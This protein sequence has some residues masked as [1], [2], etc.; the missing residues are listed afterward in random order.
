MAS[1]HCHSEI[2]VKNPEENN[3]STGFFHGRREQIRMTIFFMLKL[4]FYFRL[5]RAAKFFRT[6][7]SA[8]LITV[9]LFLAVFSA[10][11]VGLY[12]FFLRGF[13]FL[14]MDTYLAEPISL[15]FYELFLLVLGAVIMFSSL[16]TGLFGLFRR[17]DDNWLLSSPGYR[18]LPKLVLI[19]SVISGLWPL[20]IV[21]LPTV[22]A[23][24]KVYSLSLPGI[25]FILLSF[26][27]YL[28]VIS[29]LTLL[30]IIIV[31]KFLFLI[32]KRTNRQFFTFGRLVTA[33]I[34]LISVA[35]IFIWQQSINTDIIELFKANRPENQAIDLNSI[36]QNFL[37]LPSHPIAMSAFAW[38][39]HQ[40]GWALV[41]F[42]ELLVLAGLAVTAYW[43]GSNY[44]LSLW[45]KLQEGK[46]GI[47]TE[48]RKR[49]V[50]KRGYLFPGGAIKSLFTKEMLVS[51]RNS[52]SI[53][54]FSFLLFIW[55]TQAALNFVLAANI[56]KYDL[57]ADS[58]SSVLQVLQ[59]CTA[60]FFITAFVL[61]FVFPS[62]ST[63]RRTAWILGSA[64]LSLKKIFWAKYLFY[65]F[66]FVIVG[67][68]FGYLNLGGLPLA[69]AQA[70][71]IVFI[72]LVVIAFITAFGLSL[73]ALFPNLETDD[74]GVISTTLPGIAFIILAL[75]YGA[76][77]GWLIYLALNKNIF[78]PLTVFIIASLALTVI[79]VTVTPKF[80][81]NK[82]F[83]REIIS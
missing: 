6:K 46:G 25:F 71:L 38:Q 62:F 2:K 3:L 58:S 64:P 23:I 37:Y 39:T 60:V 56:R 8:K 27:L 30:T 78:W 16:V 77:G 59:F 73:G 54:W 75:V 42:V 79:L 11:A 51:A 1:W 14:K 48:Y 49:R 82:E 31:G 55:L 21:F 68:I 20:L 13:L 65:L 70:S 15:Y 72:F 81:K 57:H 10:V 66:F 83:I 28:I 35:S 24:N 26:V 19:N 76:G 29:T 41:Y 43:L 53:L 67:L 44:F 32:D 9:F 61:R 47:T 52:K 40:S 12:Y 17:N 69:S 18:S 4:L 50:W 45:Q 80:L 34:L 63:E 33:C 5:K 74:P 36:S 7:K 22:L